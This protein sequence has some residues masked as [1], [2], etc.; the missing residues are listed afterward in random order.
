MAKVICT[1][2]V[3]RPVA[4]FG[5][6]TP[7]IFVPMIQELAFVYV[8][9][10]IHLQ[11]RFQTIIYEPLV[12]H[13]S[14]LTI[15][16]RV[17]ELST[18]M[19]TLGLERAHIVAWSDTGSV[20]YQF[21]LQHA[22]RC[23]SVAFLGVPDRYKLPFPINAVMQT[24]GRWPVHQ[25]VPAHV[26]HRV[27]AWFM[28]GPRVRR[29]DVLQMA[30][31]IPNLSRLFIYSCLPNMVGHRPTMVDLESPFVVVYGDKDP[32]VRPS[33]AK[34]FAMLMGHPEATCYI[35]EAEHLMPWSN[36]DAVSSAL[37]PFLE[38]V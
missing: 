1:D 37:L 12:R 3:S 8:P 35:P 16:D 27:L 30:K 29:S 2:G 4:A 18:V 25:I 23:R 10:I 6:G 38:T 33:Q 34:S 17:L 9:Q 26:L 21:A 5:K 32:V 31:G 15:D 19:S 22:A 7:V 36:P 13:D 20:A 14:Y 11:E 24:L 28:S